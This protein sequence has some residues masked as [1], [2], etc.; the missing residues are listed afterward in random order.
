M[1]RAMSSFRVIATLLR[2]FLSNH[3]AYPVFQD[4]SRDLFAVWFATG[5]G[6]GKVQG[7]LFFDLRWHWR[8]EGVNSGLDN[9]R[10]ARIQRLF[11]DG[12]AIARVI[13]AEA[14]TA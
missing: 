1:P 9:Y 14:N 2:A 13:N 12:S 7:L 6:F 5:Q 10:F 3:L 8:L 4:R 11:Y